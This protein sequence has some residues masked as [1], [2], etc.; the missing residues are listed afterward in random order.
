MGLISPCSNSHIDLQVRT[1]NFSKEIILLTKTIKYT[2]Y[3]ENII[4]QLLRSS[5]SIG[6][7]YCEA[8]ETITNKDF[9]HKISLCLKEAKET[10]YWLDLLN[11]VDNNQKINS[12]LKP[13]VDQFIK[14]FATMIKNK[15]VKM[16]SMLNANN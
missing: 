13:E 2:I 6:A 4:R 1:R 9:V 12:F 8:K 3:S 7:N 15:H 5:T 14:M 11:I 16:S 10:E